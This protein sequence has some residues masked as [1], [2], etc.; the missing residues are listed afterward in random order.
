MLF[1][2][3]LQTREL[4]RVWTMNVEMERSKEYH[5]RSLSVLALAVATMSI[6][7]SIS[8]AV[9]SYSALSTA[10]YE[11]KLLKLE[12]VNI[13]K[14]NE[15]K[16]NSGIST[17][18]KRERRDANPVSTKANFFFELNTMFGTY[19]R[20]YKDEMLRKCFYN[21]SVICIQGQRGIPGPPGLKGD[22]GKAG[23]EGPPGRQGLK[24]EKG[25]RGLRGPP[26]PT[27]AKPVITEAPGNASVLEGKDA[28]FKC[29]SE[30]YPKPRIK[31]L[32]KGAQITRSQS[33]FEILNET[34]LQL[35]RVEYEDRGYVEC[36][37]T[38][39][40]G[41]EKAAANLTVFVPP[42]IELDRTQVVRYIGQDLSI[43]CSAFGNP[44]PSLKWRKVH[45]R[46]GSNVRQ[47]TDGRIH[48]TGLVKDNGGMYI[49][50][51]KNE[52]GKSEAKLI[53]IT[54]DPPPRQF[55]VNSL[56]CGGNLRG[57]YGS[58]ASPNYP[59]SYG[60]NLNCRWTITAPRGSVLTI[61]FISFNTESSYDRVR[62][63]TGSHSGTLV[64]EIS[65]NLSPGTQYQVDSNRVFVHFRTDGGTQRK[66]F[67]ATWHT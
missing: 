46:L 25:A 8:S 10:Q 23:P 39:F 3:I 12:L 17:S 57:A 61:R 5:E 52:W 42:E 9:T 33:R 32:Y 58:F 62:I 19:L 7:I 43:N 65:G 4:F 29:V 16:K 26:G 66:G 14:Y 6:G 56:A 59:S 37:A 27:V 28:L 15:D 13:R 54:Q 38:N 47:S 64:K 60:T 40:M 35:R 34:H 45:G 49:C 44:V 41:T 1:V 63:R 24:G 55:E 50:E 51:A 30:G 53:L 22:P 67:L 48:F 36:V 2:P 11:I 31:W 21:E 18:G 20:N